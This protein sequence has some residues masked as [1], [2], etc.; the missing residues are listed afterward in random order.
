MAT[1]SVPSSPLSPRAL[2]PGKSFFPLPS[3]HTLS[4]KRFVAEGGSWRSSLPKRLKAASGSI[5]QSSDTIAEVQAQL[6]DAK[7]KLTRV[8]G[9]RQKEEQKMSTL[10]GSLTMIKDIVL[11][12]MAKN[13][14]P[15][16]K[17]KLRRS[18]A[19]LDSMTLPQ[20]TVS[21][22]NSAE[23]LE[24]PTRFGAPYVTPW[25]IC[26]RLPSPTCH[27]P[28]GS[29]CTSSHH[30]PTGVLCPCSHHRTSPTSPI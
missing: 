3:P 15:R 28:G 6:K 9:E 23:T 2:I 4:S 11:A 10:T 20:T 27:P 1:H 13:T 22:V 26:Y 19:V 16:R 30:R 21:P 25:S 29:C 18:M 8:Q 7:G 24:A 5:E 14:S 17:A 12:G